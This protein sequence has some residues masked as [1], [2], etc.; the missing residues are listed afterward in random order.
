MQPDALI[1]EALDAHYGDSHVLQQIALRVPQGSLVALLG[2]NAAGKS[3]L[4]HTVVG[5]QPVTRGR[6]R[7]FGRDVVNLTPEDIA[8]TGV[9]LVPQ[10]RRIFKSLTVR[11]NI[12]VARRRGS[13]FD[14]EKLYNWFP[15]LKRRHK[16][17][18]GSLSGGEQQMLAIARALAGGPRLVLLDEPSEGLAPQIVE[19]VAEIL[20]RLRGEGL[21]LL[22]VEQNLKFALKL[23]DHIVLLNTGRIV[24]SGTCAEAQAKPEILQQNLGLH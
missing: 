12:E 16:Q 9:A 21:S 19:N 24:F 1:I 11:E 23:A 15:V 8:G 14:V 17:L 7:C 10:G 6:I 4:L 3:T 20:T 22:L 18:A 5:F 13:T 2:R